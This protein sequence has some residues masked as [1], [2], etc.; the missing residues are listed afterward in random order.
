MFGF[1]IKIALDGSRLTVTNPADT[2]MLILFMVFTI[3]PLA[4]FINQRP[5]PVRKVIVF[6]LITLLVYGFAMDTTRLVLDHNAQTATIRHFHW[7]HW[8]TRLHLRAQ[9]LGVGFIGISQAHKID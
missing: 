1:H 3:W 8:S 7:S 6:S 5:M 4:I 2:I 9:S